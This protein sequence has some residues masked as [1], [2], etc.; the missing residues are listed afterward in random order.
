M[1]FDS[2]A[3]PSL[4]VAGELLSVK[5]QPSLFSST[6]EDSGHPTFRRETDLGE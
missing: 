5:G 4:G 2:S 1:C 3:E 6:I